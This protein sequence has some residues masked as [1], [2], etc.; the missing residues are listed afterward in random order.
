MGHS[1]IIFIVVAYKNETDKEDNLNRKKKGRTELNVFIPI[2]R[3]SI[4][5]LCRN[6][7]VET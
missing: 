1:S 2:P 4:R 6:R 5:T 3:P 7:V